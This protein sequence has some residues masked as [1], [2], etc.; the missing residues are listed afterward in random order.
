MSVRVRLFPL[1]KTIIAGSRNINNR[2]LLDL[3]I[4]ESGFSITE[5]MSGTAKGVDTLGEE[6][7]TERGFPIKRFKPDWDKH[8]RAAGP[9]RNAEMAKYGEALIAIYREGSRGTMSMC[10]IAKSKGLKVHEY[11]VK[12]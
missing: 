4:L 6:F 3:V 10:R 11:I 9:I 5:V 2:K 8:G 12:D 1:M 7:A